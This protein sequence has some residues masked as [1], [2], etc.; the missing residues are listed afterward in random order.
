[1]KQKNRSQLLFFSLILNLFLVVSNADLLAYFD[2]E[3]ELQDF[4]LET[5][6]IKLPEYPDAFNP[7]MIHWRGSLLLCFRSRDPSTG[8][9]NLLRITELD[10]NFDPTG[11]IYPLKIYHDELAGCKVQDPRMLVIR[12]ELY[13]IYSNTWKLPSK[14][15][16][17]KARRV[18]VSKVL[19][20]GQNFVAYNP[21]VFLHFDGIKDNKCE[22]NWVP[23]EY[24]GD[25]LLSYTINPHKVFLPIFEKNECV[26]VATSEVVDTWEWG[27]IRGGTQAVIVD[28]QYLAFFHSSKL[29]RS[30]QSNGELMTHYFMG[31]YTF[32]RH[33]PFRL[34]QISPEFIVGKNFYNGPDYN[35][36]K[37]L[38]VVFPGGL[39]AYKE[40]IYVSF[41]RQD[42]EM[43]IVKLDKKKLLNSLILTDEIK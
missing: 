11:K 7:S 28:N 27:E 2:L 16:R 10:E 6:Q 29:M 14:K 8:I 17:N 42:H 18:F 19:F 13:I 38:R 26:T 25:L 34:T 22:K 40:N 39:I 31:A 5:K 4:V 9:T 35:T 20:D 3:S 37:P 21:K 12:D 24:N 32:E 36:W 23:F 1:M 33:P 15:A 41:G 43:W 30:E